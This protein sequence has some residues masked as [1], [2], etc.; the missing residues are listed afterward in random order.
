MQYSFFSFAQIIS[1]IKT[2]SILK[3]WFSILVIHSLIFFFCPSTLLTEKHGFLCCLKRHIT[4]FKSWNIS[5]HWLN[6]MFQS[7]SL[8]YRTRSLFLLD[9]II[10]SLSSQN[11]YIIR[12]LDS[13]LTSSCSGSVLR[14]DSI[15]SLRTAYNC[16]LRALDF[17]DFIVLTVVVSTRFN[18]ALDIL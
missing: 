9:V 10:S 2:L 11:L 1:S 15:S 18:S 7:M 12:P 6:F 16:E 3:R 13:Q 8:K 4:S 17:I 5:T 14:V